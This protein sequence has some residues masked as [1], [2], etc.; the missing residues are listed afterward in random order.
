[1][2]TLSAHLHAADCSIGQA[3]GSTVRCMLRHLC[4]IGKGDLLTEWS[5][6]AWSIDSAILIV[7]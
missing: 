5:M 2:H 7:P 1:M 6:R 4:A 3:R